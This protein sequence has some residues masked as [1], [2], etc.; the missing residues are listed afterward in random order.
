VRVWYDGNVGC[1]MMPSGGDASA[2]LSRWPGA[3]GGVLR[4]V[5]EI[6]GVPSR[7][8]PVAEAPVPT[9]HVRYV[10]DKRIDWQRVE[11]ITTLSQQ[12]RQWTNFGP[13]SRALE[14]VLEHVLDLPPQRAVVMCASATIG[15][16]A[17]AGLSAVKLGR[18]PRW[19][20]CSYTFFSQRTGPFADAVVVDCDDRGLVDLDAVAALPDGAWD[21]L[22]VT[23]TFATLRD[24]RIFADFCQTR[25]KSLIVDSAG[26]LLGPDRA[27]P[28]HP[29]EAI[30]F[31]HT[32][33]W[34]VG[35]GGC[36]VVD[37]AEAELARS[38][39]NFGIGGPRSLRPLASNGKI[40]D[41]ACA[42]ILERLER[43]P[44]WAPSYAAQRMRIEALCD[45]MGV[46]R[47]AEAPRHAILAS[48][49]AL[50]ASP[51]ARGDLESV[52][53]DL[54]KYYPPLD[55][56]TRRAQRIFA[57]MINIPAHGGMAAV[58]TEK[59]S[60]VLRRLSPT[61]AERHSERV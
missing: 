55:E 11:Q 56:R 21:G 10:E 24:V 33:P 8:G 44:A 48:V 46:P 43:L 9:A 35:E 6:A 20:V 7:R 3:K 25:G 53:F 14:R 1:T 29:D 59:L 49:P 18:T 26:A 4:E 5:A 19:V 50:A 37:R 54:G 40:S 52:G 36:I 39:L 31:H 16:Y 2:A 47:L 51:T 45:A 58:D 28:G 17:L 32:K 23:N 57:R 27:W 41:V 30:S 61:A 34:G 15:L 13:V 38:A 42:A 12:A 22:V 60:E